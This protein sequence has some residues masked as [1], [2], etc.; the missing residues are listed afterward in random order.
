MTENADQSRS[1]ATEADIQE[2]S[3]DVTEI[4]DADSPTTSLEVDEFDAAE[5]G[6]SVELDPDEYR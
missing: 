2:R 6:R 3:E 5:Q 1:E 4:A